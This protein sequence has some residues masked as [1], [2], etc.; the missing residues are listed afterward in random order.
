MTQLDHILWF[1]SAAPYIQAFRKK[2]FVIHV[3]GE[4]V[5][6]PLYHNLIHDIAL[7]HHLGIRLVLVHGSRCQIDERLQQ[8]AID[9]RFHNGIRITSFEQLQ[10]LL[11]TIQQVQQNITARLSMGLP[12]TPMSGSEISVVSGNF[13]TGM[14]LGILDG[15]DMQYSGKV[16]SINSNAI[17]TLLSDHIVVLSHIGYSKSGELFNLHAEEVASQTAI[18]LKAEKLIYFHE[19]FLTNQHSDRFSTADCEQWLTDNPQ[20]STF[21]QL[22]ENAVSAVKHKVDRV[23]ILD[24]TLEG[25]LLQELFTREGAGMMITDLFYEGLREASIDDIGGILKLIQPLEASGSLV[26]RSREQIELEINNFLVIEK[27]GLIIACAAA[28]PSDN[29]EML[30]IACLAVHPEYR[31]QGLGEQI[32]KRF[33]QKARSLEVTKLFILT[34]RSTHWFLEQGFQLCQ[35]LDCLPPQKLQRIDPARNS[36]AM[37]KLLDQTDGV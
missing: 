37:I 25:G 6:S 5:R 9:S 12:N 20:P 8:K 13:V 28:N 2:T 27:D 16:R 36:Q 29:P 14:P 32:I 17:H 34:T 1:R 19:Q 31:N 15:V 30:E 22:L 26:K 10:L 24:Q 3:S 18:A 11:P 21:K 4:M 33:E 7:C 35:G 23:H